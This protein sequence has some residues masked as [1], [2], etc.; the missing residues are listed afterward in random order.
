MTPDKIKEISEKWNTVARADIDANLIPL[1]VE[2]I[3]EATA[4]F[5]G[6]LNRTVVFHTNNTIQLQSTNQQ[7]REALELAI[8]MAEE[9]APQSHTLTLLK[10]A[11]SATPAPNDDS[12]WQPIETAPKDGIRILVTILGRPQNTYVVRW[13]N[14]KWED[15]SGS[16]SYP[17]H[18]MPLPKPP[19][20][21]TDKPTVDGPS[22]AQCD[23]ILGKPHY[24]ERPKP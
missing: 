8:D 24:T 23:E 20:N 4:E 11:L 19:T 13:K 6:E 3:N 17:T 9:L 15:Q 7:L 2:A 12:P 5:Q 1:F 21:S 22:S 14:E 16:W 18:W 10:N